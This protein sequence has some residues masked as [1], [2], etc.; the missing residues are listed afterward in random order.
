[1]VIDSEVCGYAIAESS[2]SILRSSVNFFPG[3]ML[4]VLY[5]E[6]AIGNCVLFFDN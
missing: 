3:E 2:L 5:S 4:K 6:D 1:M